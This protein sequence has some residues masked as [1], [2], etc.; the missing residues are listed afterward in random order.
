MA[1]G[2]NNNNNDNNNSN[3]YSNNRNSNNRN[4]YNR[5]SNWRGNDV[6]P[7]GGGRED[8]PRR[9]GRRDRDAREDSPH[10]TGRRDAREDS[11]IREELDDDD[12]DDDRAAD[13]P[14]RET[15][16]ERI[17]GLEALL[18]EKDK[19]VEKAEQTSNALLAEKDKVC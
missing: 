4:S 5:N 19:A 3:Y 8:S 15:L 11:R 6:H 7:L 17:R 2:R 9:T 14:S 12:V 13:L 1:R 16:M 10:R 18:V